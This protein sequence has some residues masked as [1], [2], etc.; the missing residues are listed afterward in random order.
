MNVTIGVLKQ[1]REGLKPDGFFLGSMIGGDSVFELRYVRDHHPNSKT[2][3]KAEHST[4]RYL[5]HCTRRT[6]LQLAEMNQSGGVS[7]RISP[8]ADPRDASNLLQR[9]G[10]TLL[11]VDVE[12]ITISYPSMWELI[13]DLRDM[14]ESGAVLGRRAFVKRDVLIAAEAIYKGAFWRF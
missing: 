4:S 6:A 5:P 12:D 9:A 11:T 14:G 13:E 1:I 3:S 10:F 8:M 7:P 2:Q